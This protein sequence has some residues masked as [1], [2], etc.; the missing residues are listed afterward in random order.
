MD[1]RHRPRAREKMRVYATTERIGRDTERLIEKSDL[2]QDMSRSHAKDTTKDY[3][4]ADT[5]KI[6]NDLWR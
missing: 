3:G 5:K 1:L 4:Q 2:A 6:E